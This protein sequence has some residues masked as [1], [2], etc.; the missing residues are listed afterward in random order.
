[1]DFMPWTDDYLTDIRKIDEQHRWLVDA[2]NTLH[3]EIIRSEP[4]K[5]RIG[6]ILYGL[7]DYARNHFREE[8]DLFSRYGYPESEAHIA[9]HGKF[10]RTA[11]ELLD[12]HENGGVMTEKALAFLKDWLN[13]HILKN[14][15]NYVAFFREKGVR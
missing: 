6:E 4:D 13:H 11:A 10:N 12:E 15:Q 14:D 5:N 9:E 3:A 7:V 1:M 8:E 2:T